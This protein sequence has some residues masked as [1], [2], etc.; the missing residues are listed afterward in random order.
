MNLLGSGEYFDPHA[1]AGLLKLFLRELPVHVLTRELQH[2]FLQVCDLTQRRD[3]VNE[4][5]SLIAQLPVANYTLLRFL[6][7]HLM[8]VVQNEKLNKMSL[9]N[10]GIV[11]SPTLGI[12]ATLFSLLLTEFAHVFRVLDD[13]PAPLRIDDD[14]AISEEAVPVSD[15]IRRMGDST[16]AIPR[17]WDAEKSN[18][19]RSRNSMYYSASGADTL[20]E[21]RGEKLEGTRESEDEEIASDAEIDGEDSQDDG[22]SGGLGSPR[23][24]SPQTTPMSTTSDPTKTYFDLDQ[25]TATAPGFPQSIE[26]EKQFR[27]PA[28]EKGLTILV[29]PEQ[30]VKDRR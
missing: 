4:L 27:R 13:Q 17:Q 9:R 11:F 6:T 15:P 28:K 24:V 16:V 14:D 19:R 5:G 1:I 29:H 12:P 7:A 26:E 21:S 25:K 30:G 22:Q 8:H 18:R 20:L 10:V 2:P 3:K 23:D